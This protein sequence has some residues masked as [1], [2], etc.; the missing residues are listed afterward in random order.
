MTRIKKY[1]MRAKRRTESLDIINF[2]PNGTPMLSKHF[3]QVFQLGV[4]E[5]RTD[6]YRALMVRVKE[7]VPEMGW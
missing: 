2:I 7:F 5:C 3:Q 6:N 4:I 1:A